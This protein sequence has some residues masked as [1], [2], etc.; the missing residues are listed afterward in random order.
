MHLNLDPLLP[1]R[2][3]PASP[4]VRG[5]LVFLVAI[6]CFAVVS[7]VA[8]MSYASQHVELSSGRTASFWVGM[9]LF[10]AAPLVT[11]LSGSVDG[12]LAVSLIAG[13]TVSIIPAYY[14]GGL[15]S[16][17]MIW[18][19]VIPM[20]ATLYL[21]AW[22]GI[23]AS[24]VG[25]L[26]VVGFFVLELRNELP[27]FVP[28]DENVLVLL[29][30]L[31]ALVFMAYMSL[32]ARGALK[33]REEALLEAATEAKESARVIEERDEQLV[34][35]QRLES[36]GRLTGGVAHDFNNLL[37][38]ING[39]AET[40]IEDVPDGSEVQE[41]LSEVLKAGGRAALLIRQLLAFSRRQTLEPENVCLNHVVDEFLKMVRR[42]M[43]ENVA[44]E[45]RLAVDLWTVF[46]DPNSIEQ[47]LMN[48][49]VNARDAMPEGGT[50]CIE[51]ANRVLREGDVSGLSPGEYIR[52]AVCDTGIGMD[53]KT[54]EQV[55]EPYFTTKEM[56]RGT[57]LGL[58]M[59]YGTVTQSGGGIT[60]DSR[61]GEGCEIAM[62]LPR[63]PQNS[64]AVC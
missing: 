62:L 30:L 63:S 37:T 29:N 5:R 27:H 21:R 49:A 46:V 19:V 52:V 43:P 25:A 3:R 20:V 33:R 48:M 57:G 22:F 11:R 58:A 51:T 13:M 18:L 64:P 59:A 36:I 9:G 12:G 17:F 15:N 6:T 26:I 24:F 2:A 10:L 4:E 42:M 47:V 39:H 44:M 1:A 53:E 23:A 16:V 31:L 32:A 35:A 14:Q 54:R 50:L 8:A 61:P 60:I 40:A 55:F 56:G 34:R 41:S 38:V 28:S 45:A 7:L